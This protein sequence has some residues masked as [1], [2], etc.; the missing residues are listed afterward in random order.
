MRIEAAELPVRGH[1]ETA[2]AAY[3]QFG[4]AYFQLGVACPFLEA[5]S[6]SIHPDRPLVCRE[7]QVTSPP[8][9]CAHPDSGGV[10][11]VPVPVRVWAVFARSVSPTETL[12]WMPLVEALRFSSQQPKSDEDRAGPARVEALLRELPR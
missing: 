7:Y 2:K 5:E 1:P 9:A 12:E 10:R 11:Q 3:R 8:A 6:C 4:L